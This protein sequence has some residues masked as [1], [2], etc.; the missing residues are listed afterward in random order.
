MNGSTEVVISCYSPYDLGRKLAPL[1]LPL[2][3][4]K[5]PQQPHASSVVMV[6][7]QPGIDQNE[8]SS[9][10]MDHQN[11]TPLQKKMKIPMLPKDLSHDLYPKALFSQSKTPPRK[12]SRS[13]EM[14]TLDQL[15]TYQ[16]WKTNGRHG[17]L[18]VIIQPT[19]SHHFEVALDGQFS[20]LFKNEGMNEKCLIYLLDPI[21][22]DSNQ[23][24][25]PF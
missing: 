18:V 4:I 22:K 21:W 25:H 15:Q 10:W 13:L 24:T 11:G 19:F 12:S 7:I 23:K 14:M 20:Q 8:R 17:I 9:D 2:N 6:T 1:Y 5:P 16:G 3:P